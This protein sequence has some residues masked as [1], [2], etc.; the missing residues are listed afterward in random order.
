MAKFYR[1]RILSRVA[2]AHVSRWLGGAVDNTTPP[3]WVIVGSNPDPLTTF[4]IG[5]TPVVHAG[6]LGG[7]QGV[8]PGGYPDSLISFLPLLFP[9]CSSSSLAVMP[10]TCG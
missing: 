5:A 3:D 2:H 7:V 1:V 6:G 8:V 9:L 10:V 4:N